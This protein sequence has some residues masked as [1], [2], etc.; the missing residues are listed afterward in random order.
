MA[1]FW[2]N[3]LDKWYD[4]STFD[5][6]IQSFIVG[7][8]IST[9]TI[10]G[11]NPPL[12]SET[13]SDWQLWL[14]KVGPLFFVLEPLVILIMMLIVTRLMQVAEDYRRKPK[15][16]GQRLM[17]TAIFGVA[18]LTGLFL[19]FLLAPLAV[20]SPLF[21]EVAVAIMATVAGV[22]DVF[23]FAAFRKRRK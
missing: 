23:A 18:G 14:G 2:K 19:A 3:R 20:T 15:I 22:G 21:F 7:A 9:I 1:Y 8:V 5:K 4:R 10:G 17:L 16:V 13:L 6:S 12:N 11:F